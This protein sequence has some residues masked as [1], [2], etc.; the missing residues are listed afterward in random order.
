MRS[1]SSHPSSPPVHL[2]VA[3]DEAGRRAAGGR[4]GVTAGAAAGRDERDDRHRVRVAMREDLADLDLVGERFVQRHRGDV[5]CAAARR[6]RWTAV[7]VPAPTSAAAD[8]AARDRVAADVQHLL[9]SAAEEPDCAT[10]RR[11]VTV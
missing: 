4:A 3:W 1:L 6:R 7:S 8:R 9:G 2:P 10:T 5:P 11:V